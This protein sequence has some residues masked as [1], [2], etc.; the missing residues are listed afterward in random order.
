[1]H[2]CVCIHICMYVCVCANV[3]VYLSVTPLL[4]Q[5]VTSVSRPMSGPCVP[6]T[7]VT[8]GLEAGKEGK[9]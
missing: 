3:R 6:P 9:Y 4:A 2:V 7:A 5:A 8:Y 1:M